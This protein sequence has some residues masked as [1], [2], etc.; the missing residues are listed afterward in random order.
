MHEISAN[1]AVASSSSFMSKEINALLARLS[2][3]NSRNS[4]GK[5]ELVITFNL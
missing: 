3:A 2:N 4:T 1:V 5:K